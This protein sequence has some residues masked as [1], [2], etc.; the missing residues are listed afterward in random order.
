MFSRGFM[1]FTQPVLTSQFSETQWSQWSPEVSCTDWH[2]AVVIHR[3]AAL[4]CH[5]TCPDPSEQHRRLAR[6]IHYSSAFIG[7]VKILVIDVSPVLLFKSDVWGSSCGSV[8]MFTAVLFIDMQHG[9][10]IS[11]LIHFT[12]W[13]TSTF[14]CHE[15]NI[16]YSYFLVIFISQCGNARGMFYQLGKKKKHY[17]MVYY[18]LKITK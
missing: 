9:H 12:L 11:L 16:L 1:R 5:L 17:F 3:Y 13:Q 10:F 8:P 18:I 4:F 7:F 6:C 14:I 15:S 2:S